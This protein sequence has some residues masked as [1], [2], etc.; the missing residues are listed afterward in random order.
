MPQ[1]RSVAF[2]ANGVLYY[3]DNDIFTSIA[4][5]AQGAGIVLP[6]DFEAKYMALMKKNSG[7][8]ASTKVITESVLD[9][10]EI[11][12]S[13]NR[14][15]LAAA[16]V[17]ASREIKL[18]PEVLPTLVRLKE[19]GIDTGVITNTLQ[20]TAQKWSWFEEHGIA[21]YLDRIISSVD[22][23]V[24]K[25]DPLIYNKYIE[26]CGCLPEEIAFVGHETAELRGA[27]LAGLKC[28]A[29]RPDQ[30]GLVK[31]E[32]NSFSDLLKLI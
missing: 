22:V 29:F 10:W 5:T 2:D 28:L 16:I 14:Q 31:P 30:P 25:P 17:A 19:L 27:K 20:T 4:A 1:I 6:P 8:G 9:S 13:Q 3:R 12:D 21:P 24:T 15:T 11:R 32:F 7:G 18:F 26:D 23:G